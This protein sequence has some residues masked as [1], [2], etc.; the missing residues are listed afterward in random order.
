MN[1]LLIVNRL[2]S[3]ASAVFLVLQALRKK[4]TMADTPEAALAVVA[5]AP[6]APP[7]ADAAIATA[8]GDKATPPAEINSTAVVQSIVQ[9]VQAHPDIPASAAPSV[10]TSILSGLMQAEPAIFAVSRASSKTQTE[11]GLGLG[12]AQIILGAF[13][14]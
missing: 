12:L 8:G 13:L 7:V 11:V 4:P 9:T 5:P 1:L 3:A 14:H 2:A 6:A 10:I